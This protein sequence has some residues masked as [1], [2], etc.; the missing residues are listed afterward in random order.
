M[1]KLQ[2]LIS[3]H[4]TAAVIIVFVLIA[5]IAGAALMH[6]IHVVA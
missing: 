5:P 1:T 3:A 2:A 4:K 6:A